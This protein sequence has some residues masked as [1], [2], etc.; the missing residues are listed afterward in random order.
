[1]I[2]N[3]LQPFLIAFT[4]LII[5]FLFFVFREYY[6]T[7]FA[8]RIFV[9]DVL[10]L[11]GSS[12]L[13]YLIFPKYQ[14]VVKRPLLIV[15]T[16][17]TVYE[18]IDNIIFYIQHGVFSKGSRTDLAEAVAAVIT[19]LV[20]FIIAFLVKLDQRGIGRES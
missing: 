8:I 11:L 10:G 14:S 17:F 2:K 5:A 16:Y 4:A 9:L 19:F 13:Y 18:I 3:L 1:M 6:K 15:F 7:I 12:I 20:T